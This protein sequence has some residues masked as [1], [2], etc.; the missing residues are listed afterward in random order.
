MTDEKIFE[1][2]LTHDFI[3]QL[4]ES[5]PSDDESIIGDESDFDEDHYT[6]I[7]VN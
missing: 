4:F 2:D 7:E 3:F 6:A 5:I 1:K